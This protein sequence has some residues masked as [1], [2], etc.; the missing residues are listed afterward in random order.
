MLHFC[1]LFPSHTEYAHHAAHFWI[2]Q[3]METIS[4]NLMTRRELLD[5][6]ARIEPLGV[7]GQ[8]IGE[9]LD[10]EPQERAVDTR[11]DIFDISFNHDIIEEISYAVEQYAWMLAEGH[12]VHVEE[13]D[14]VETD[15][16]RF[17]YWQTLS[18]KWHYL[19]LMVDP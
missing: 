16:A 6:R 9:L 14:V 12:V 17:H 1:M 4:L 10:Q 5:S 8:A 19:E 11:Y 7:A 15:S 3:T 2:P 18:E 13:D